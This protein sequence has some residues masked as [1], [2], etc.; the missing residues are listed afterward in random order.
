MF[1][2]TRKFALGLM[3]A[4]TIAAPF[5]AASPAAASSSCTRSHLIQR[6]ETLSRIA[7]TYGS[8]VA[9]LQRINGMGSS[10]RIYAGTQ[11]CVSVTQSSGTS[12]VVQSG[13]TLARI[14]RRFG[15]DMTVLARVNNITDV[16]KIYVG[17]TLIIP[18]FTIQ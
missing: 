4:I 16:N 18:D 9:E 7:R 6:G 1:K 17:T 12:Y 15:V 2:N 3:T 13:D 14:A 10:T 5:I 8:S 11:L